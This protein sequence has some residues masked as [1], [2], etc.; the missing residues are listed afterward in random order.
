MTMIL[1]HGGGRKDFGCATPL[2]IR[3]CEITIPQCQLI[4]LWSPF[5]DLLARLVPSENSGIFSQTINKIE[6][7]TICGDGEFLHSFDQR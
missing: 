7:L 2:H 1:C 6:P 4:F 3:L 5:E